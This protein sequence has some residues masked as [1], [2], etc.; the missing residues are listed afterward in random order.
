MLPRIEMLHVLL[1]FNIIPMCILAIR[2]PRGCP[3]IEKYSDVIG[4]DDFS[5]PLYYCTK[6]DEGE[7]IVRV[8]QFGSP[9]G[10]CKPSWERCETCDSKEKNIKETSHAVANDLI[11]YIDKKWMLAQEKVYDE[12][13]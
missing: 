8:T 2:P 9:V 13:C 4:S 11:D 6:K 5:P 10:K 1:L 7:D 12:D 3:I